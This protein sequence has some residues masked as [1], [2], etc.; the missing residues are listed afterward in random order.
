MLV[1]WRYQLEAIDPSLSESSLLI[2]EGGWRL[3]DAGTQAHAAGTVQLSDPSL[4]VTTSSSGVLGLCNSPGYSGLRGVSSQLNFLCDTPK[5]FDR[6]ILIQ[7][8]EEPM[9]T[10]GKPI[11]LSTH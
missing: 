11:L 4:T 10:S 2:S 7:N 3:S 9:P 5:F 8:L 6:T 1:D